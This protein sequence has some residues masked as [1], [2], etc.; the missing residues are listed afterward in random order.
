MAWRG[1]DTIQVAQRGEGKGKEQRDT[2]KNV[3]VSRIIDQTK[4]ARNK[5]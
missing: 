1:R 4:E 5:Q 3:V 2:E